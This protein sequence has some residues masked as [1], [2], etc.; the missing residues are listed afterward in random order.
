MK[1]SASQI[2]KWLKCPR[3]W[4]LRY[5]EKI[6]EPKSIHLFRGTFIHTY[7]ENLHNISLREQ[8]INKNNYETKLPEIAYNLFVKQLDEQ[9]NNFGTLGET[10]REQL[11]ELFSGDEIII[12][13]SGKRYHYS[14]V[15]QQSVNA[16]QT[17]IEHATND[18]RL[19][20]YS[21]DLGGARSG[22]IVIIARP[23]SQGA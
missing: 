13:Y 20:L 7:I 6:Y 9:T 17:E 5:N 10:Y 21:C 3:A 8:G 16:N 23:T 12:D 15:E 2:I 14:V 22:R 1:A 18:S 19:T 11:N 4:A